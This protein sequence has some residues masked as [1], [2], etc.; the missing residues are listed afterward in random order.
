MNHLEGLRL[1]SASRTAQ[2]RS[3]DAVR[4]RFQAGPFD[5]SVERTLFIFPEE[6][7]S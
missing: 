2:R 4:R 7:T 1:S 6:T 5:Y 3:T